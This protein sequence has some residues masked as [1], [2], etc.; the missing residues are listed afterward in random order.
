MKKE[1]E[2]KKEYNPLEKVKEPSVHLEVVQEIS[3]MKCKESPLALRLMFNTKCG[4]DQDFHT[5]LAGLKPYSDE[6]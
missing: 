1:P 2:I 6:N 4:C 3:R 5:R